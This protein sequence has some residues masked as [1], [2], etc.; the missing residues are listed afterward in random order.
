MRILWIK[1]GGLVPT[2]TGGKIRSYH[3]AREVA[4]RHAVTLFTFYP[5]HDGDQHPKLA[6]IFERVEL[7]PLRLPERRGWREGAQFARNAAF[8]RP[9]TLHKYYLPEVRT[10]LNAL[11]AQSGWDLL[12][13][14]FLHPAGLIDDMR[15]WRPTAFGSWPVG[16]STA[17]WSRRSEAIR[18]WRTTY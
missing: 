1:A 6:E 2:D 5:E 12:L 13:C 14:D 3:I 8:G 17:R 4:R 16:W 15:R 7:T 18:G 11:L 10:R 9:H